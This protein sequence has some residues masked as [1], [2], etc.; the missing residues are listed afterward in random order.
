MYVKTRVSSQPFKGSSSAYDLA[1][2]E[3][4]FFKLIHHVCWRAIDVKTQFILLGIPF[5]KSW[6]SKF[7][8]PTVNI[9]SFQLLC[10]NAFK[11]VEKIKTI[12]ST[13]MAACGLQPGLE[14]S[15]APEQG[16]QDV[17]TMTNFAFAM[18]KILDD[19]NYNS[20]NQFHLRIG[21]FV[22]NAMLPLCLKAKQFDDIIKDV[23]WAMEKFVFYMYL[24]GHC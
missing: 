24:I 3:Q 15:E 23:C 16:E 18:I 2:M 1:D 11:R 10:R 21:E 9:L 14:R 8:D 20:Y 17:I 5:K 6:E 13:Y 19:I 4:A 7:I 22:S 12:G